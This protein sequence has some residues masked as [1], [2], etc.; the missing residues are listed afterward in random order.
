[1][2]ALTKK[3][4]ELLRDD[5]LFACLSSNEVISKA[6]AGLHVAKG[7]LEQAQGNLVRAENA[8]AAA[9]RLVADS[10]AQLV[11]LESEKARV[12]RILQEGEI[13]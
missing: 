12:M 1:M 2:D 4:F 3:A 9:Q 5:L 8:H 11:K 6:A 13:S 10:E 7:N